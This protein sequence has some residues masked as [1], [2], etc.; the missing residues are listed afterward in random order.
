[1][2][3]RPIRAPLLAALTLLVVTAGPVSGQ[4]P[5]AVARPAADSPEAVTQRYIATLKAGDFAA[6]ARLMHPSA[7]SAVRRLAMVLAQRDQSGR[8]RQEL[9]GSADPKGG[10]LTDAQVYER[11]LRGT[12]GAQP[13]AL[14]LMKSARAEI[15]GHVNEGAEQAHVVYRQHLDYQGM[16]LNKVDV[17]TLRRANGEWRA[18]LTADFEQMIARMSKAG[19]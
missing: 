19:T 12:V 6:T 7:L 4:A 13:A 9:F 5:A 8:T 14:E 3:P 1:M 2:L 10:S 11:F 15:L 16:K 17:L 18:M